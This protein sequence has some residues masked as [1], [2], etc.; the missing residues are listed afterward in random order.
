MRQVNLELIIQGE[1]SQK[2]KNKYCINAYICNLKNAI[3][4]GVE[5]QT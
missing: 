2:K 5:T 4:E 3:K 1:V